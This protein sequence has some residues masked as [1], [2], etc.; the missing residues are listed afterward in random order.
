MGFCVVT[1]T[2]DVPEKAKRFVSYYLEQGAERI[3]LFLENP[4]STIKN[5]F[6]HLDRVET[7]IL[8][9]DFLENLNLSEDD[10][11]PPQNSLGS[12]FY[13]QLKEDWM[14]RVDIDELMYFKGKSIDQALN[15]TTDAVKT[16]R[17][18]VIE[19]IGTDRN[20]GLLYFRDHVFGSR[21]LEKIYGDMW[22]IW[23]KSAGLVGH[24][25]GKTAIRRGMRNVVVHTHGPKKIPFQFWRKKPN[26]NDILK[27]DFI[28]REYHPDS[29][30]L[31]FNK[32]PIEEWGSKFLFRART[33][34][35]RPHSLGYF[36]QKLFS[37][38]NSDI[39]LAEAFDQ[40][41]RYIFHFDEDRLAALD[42]CGK[43][44]KIDLDLDAL[45]AKYFP[46]G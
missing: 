46:E 31:H 23:R 45:V 13:K 38:R 2:N 36:L 6:D 41:H 25:S 3:Y 28:G 18:K 17:P 26:R 20:D 44:I 12:Y 1:I 29:Y 8:T 4:N 33:R 39:S 11:G 37:Q 30:L 10:P 16:I 15:E 19:E 35:L 22:R 27:L 32:E 42:G 43:L 21:N 5:D 14:L 24:R 40:L 9:P 34:S 7:K